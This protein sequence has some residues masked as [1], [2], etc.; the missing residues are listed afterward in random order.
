MEG[1]AVKD[2]MIPGYFPFPF[3]P[4]DIQ[5]KFMRHLYFAIQEK[6]IGIFESPTGTVRMMDW[7]GLFDWELAHSNLI[8]TLCSAVAI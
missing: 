6:K 4:Y 1:D 7:T 3:A 5:E 2:F 8:R